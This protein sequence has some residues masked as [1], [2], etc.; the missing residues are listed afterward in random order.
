MSLGTILLIIVVLMLIGAFPSWPH[1]R[2][3]GY[4]PSGGLG[5]VLVILLVLFLLGK[6]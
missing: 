4:G 2:G 1:S 3:W 6:I 5:L